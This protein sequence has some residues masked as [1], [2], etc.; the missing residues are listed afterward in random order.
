MTPQPEGDW[1]PLDPNV[2][3]LWRFEAA[4]AAVG[5]AALGIG[6]DFLVRELSEDGR[7]RWPLPFGSLTG[8][9]FLAVLVLGLLLVTKKHQ[10]WRYRL[11]P[12]DLAVRYG[13]FW[14]TWR[15]VSRPRIQHVD[16]TAG[17]IARALGL[18]TVSVFVG[19]NVGATVTIPGLSEAESERLRQTLVRSAPPS[20]ETP[21]G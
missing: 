6:L 19:G 5:W 20:E 9:G 13:I 14:K 17:P 16:V 4:L 1:R 12:D 8:G 15:Y 21:S 3:T 10:N 7:V 11:R 2:R 18:R